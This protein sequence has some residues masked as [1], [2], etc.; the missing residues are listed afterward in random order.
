MD[1]ARLEE[2][3]IFILSLM[4]LSALSLSLVGSFSVVCVTIIKR[5][6]LNKQV[7]PLL[8]L[9]LADFLASALLTATT[10]LNFLSVEVRSDVLLCEFG[11]PLALM[12]Y[13]ISFLLSILY[14]CESTSGIQGRA[15]SDNHTEIRGRSRWFS[16]IYACV[17]LVP[18]CAYVVYV[19]TITNS[20]VPLQPQLDPSDNGNSLVVNPTEYYCTSCVLFLHIQGDNCSDVDQVHDMAVRGSLFISL[21]SVLIVC[22]VVYCKLGR[23]SGQYGESVMFPVESD[24]L[25]RRRLRGAVSTSQLIIL[26]P[27]LCWTPA[28]L[29][30][31]LSF[32]KEITQQ[33][34]FPLYIIQALLVSLHGLLNS[35]VYA[36]RR[37]NF[38]EVVL[39]EH[40]HLLSQRPSYRTFLEDSLPSAP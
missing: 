10:V 20:M 15:D 39:G 8:Q 24:G 4:Y 30:I 35:V 38:R 33:Q 31:S 22:T 32:V 2:W 9:G 27:I 21:L 7:K 37:P 36:W 14:A 40:V 25:C 16:I 17:W 6:D 13:C 18:F 29:L 1:T 34:L 23:W 12:F 11:L 5:H 26:V 19:G 3:Q 28:L